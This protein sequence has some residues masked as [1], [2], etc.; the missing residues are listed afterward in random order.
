[1]RHEGM[2]WGMV[3]AGKT[4]SPMEGPGPNH[5]EIYRKFAGG[6]LHGGAGVWRIKLPGWGGLGLARLGWGVRESNSVR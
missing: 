5:K 1:M 6:S 2:A 3:T 4:R